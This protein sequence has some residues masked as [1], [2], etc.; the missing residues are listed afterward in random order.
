MQIQSSNSRQTMMWIVGIAIILF[1]AAGIGAIMGWIPTSNA[2]NG[3]SATTAAAPAPPAAV[4]AAQPAR[5]AEPGYSESTRVADNNGSR[6]G[7]RECGVVESVREISQPGKGS[8]VGGVG[9]AVVG[10]VLG[11]QVG[12]GR[13][14]DL[15][16]VAGAIGGAF[17]G[18]AIEKRVNASKRYE[19]TV[20]LD[21][22][23]TRIF[24]ESTSNWR[25]GDHV[26]IVDGVIRA[27]G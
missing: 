19:I 4:R 8:G 1:C 16:T 15:A 27:N 26:R 20:R 13:G 5:E 18:N 21:G 2:N 7:C 22:G 3:S 6:S 17:A 10:G 14:N 24:N 11:H 9:G 23:S 25:S 12:G